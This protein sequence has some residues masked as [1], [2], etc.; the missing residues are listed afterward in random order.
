MFNQ[1]TILIFIAFFILL[2]F[3]FLAISE[4]KQHTL[5]DGWF[6]YFNNT[7]DGS[8]NFTLENYSEKNDFTWEISAEGKS[9]NKETI[10][11]LKGDKKSVILDKPLEKGL[12][13]ITVYHAK[14]TKEIYKNFQ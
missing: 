11:I 1:K 7:Q 3:S 2:S 5:K 10:S 13:K 8:L 4:K 9:L 12:T 14:E 6:L